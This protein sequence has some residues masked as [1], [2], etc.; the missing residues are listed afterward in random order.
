MIIGS[1][2]KGCRF[3]G[4][5]PASTSYQLGKKP[6]RTLGKAHHAAIREAGFQSSRSG[7]RARIAAVGLAAKIEKATGIEMTVFNHDYI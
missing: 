5:Q 1:A 2:H 7:L 3:W 4:Y 6:D